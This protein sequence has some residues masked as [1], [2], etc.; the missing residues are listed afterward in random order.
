MAEITFHPACVCL[1]VCALGDKLIRSNRPAC[2]GVV[3]YPNKKSFLPAAKQVF[4]CWTCVLNRLSWKVGFSWRRNILHRAHV[5]VGF[6]I[7]PIPA[8]ITPFHPSK[9]VCGG[10]GEVFCN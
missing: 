5:R 3:F 8:T 6:K 7:T 4:R 10:V 2:D 1:G 9:G